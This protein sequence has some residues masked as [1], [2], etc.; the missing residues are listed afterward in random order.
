M[1]HSNKHDLPQSWQDTTMSR[2]ELAILCYSNHEELPCCCCCAD[3]SISLALA[4]H[5]LLVVTGS[6][7]MRDYHT[8]I[9]QQENSSTVRCTRDNSTVQ[10]QRFYMVCPLSKCIHLPSKFIIGENCSKLINKLEEGNI[11][12]RQFYSVTTSMSNWSTGKTFQGIEG[13]TDS[14]SGAHRATSNKS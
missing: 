1:H 4:G 8:L 3:H 10:W 7:R 11:S 2:L 5:P 6:V 9:K 14:F 12:G 13:N